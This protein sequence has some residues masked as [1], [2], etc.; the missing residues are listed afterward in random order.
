MIQSESGLLCDATS[1]FEKVADMIEIVICDEKD[2]RGRRLLQ[3]KDLSNGTN[4]TNKGD[5]KGIVSS[6][7]TC[8]ARLH[9]PTPALRPKTY[10]L[11]CHETE[12]E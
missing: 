1:L 7:F 11:T 8:Q 12:A 9:S 3:G 10:D 2:Q 4:K 5:K 6:P